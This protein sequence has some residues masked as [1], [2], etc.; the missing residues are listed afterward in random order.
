MPFGWKRVCTCVACLDKKKPCLGLLK[1]KNER[2]QC[3]RRCTCET[4]L[5]L[6]AHHLYYVY[7]Y[8]N[9]T[10]CAALRWC[11]LS[12]RCVLRKNCIYIVA[13]LR[14]HCAFKGGRNEHIYCVWLAINIKLFMYLY[15]SYIIYVYVGGGIQDML[16]Y[17]PPQLM[18][19]ARMRSVY[20]NISTTIVKE[21]A[22]LLNL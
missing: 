4:G 1:L 8:A 20:L 13:S 2:C 19:N 17:A 6:A 21:K 15:S 16:N 10:C 12:M 3:A 14:I 7:I 18:R 22:I 11:I 9:V 5:R